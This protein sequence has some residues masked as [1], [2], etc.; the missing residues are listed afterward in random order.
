MPAKK[1][2]GVKKKKTVVAEKAPVDE[3][4]KPVHQMPEYPDPLKYTPIA[5]L[6][7]CLATPPHKLLDFEYKCM[8]TTRLFEI[9]RRIIQQHGG[10]ISD[11]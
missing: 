2:K 9:E 10:G 8:V 4:A 5:T 3:E 1:K 7:I 6:K 11:L